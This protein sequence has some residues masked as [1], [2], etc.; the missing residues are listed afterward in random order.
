M[1]N[2]S[3]SPIKKLITTISVLL[4]IVIILTFVGQYAVLALAALS[5][6]AGEMKGKKHN[7]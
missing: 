7:G 1:K 4:I 2:K 6:L 5:I 3:K